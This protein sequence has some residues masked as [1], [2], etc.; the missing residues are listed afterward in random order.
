MNK[1]QKIMLIGAIIC[2]IIGGIIGVNDP[3]AP[4]FALIWCGIGFGGNIDLIADIPG[5]FFIRL[6][7]EGFV[8][9]IKTIFSGILVWAIIFTISGPIGFLIRFFRNA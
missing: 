3:T 1:K 8:E 5:L 6:E 4:T 7:K 9:A 2:G